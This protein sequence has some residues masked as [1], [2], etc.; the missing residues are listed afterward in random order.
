MTGAEPN[1]TRHDVRWWT[2]TLAMAAALGWMG[3]RV[4]L[5]YAHILIEER[6]HAD[7]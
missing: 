6:R 5:A 4:V 3:S 7:R 1:P 2:T